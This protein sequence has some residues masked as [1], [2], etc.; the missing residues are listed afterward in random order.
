MT[1]LPDAYVRYLA[2]R[3]QQRVNAVQSTLAAMTEVERRIFREAAVM[4]YVCGVMAV[5]SRN[6]VP[7]PPDT[8]IVNEVIDSIHGF[9]DRYPITN[10][11]TRSCATCGQ[12]ALDCG[13]PWPSDEGDDGGE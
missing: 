6:N 7:I 4:G 13:H 10:S 5:P 9:D 1:V 3:D 12:R 8:D 2:A 11:L